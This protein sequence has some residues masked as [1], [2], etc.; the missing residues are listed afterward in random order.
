MT[1]AHWV[2]AQTPARTM[3][4]TMRIWPINNLVGVTDLLPPAGLDRFER[5]QESAKAF[6]KD[7]VQ[8]GPD[9]LNSDAIYGFTRSSS[10]RSGPRSYRKL[11]D[12][13]ACRCFDSI[14]QHTDGPGNRLEILDAN[15]VRSRVT[16]L[17]ISA[18]EKFEQAT[19]CSC[20]PWPGGDETRFNVFG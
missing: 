16:R 9:R 2:A 10:D 14:P 18:F 5:V 19:I 17:D 12:S 11:F 6:Q 15:V 8:I 13:L 7:M 3:A 4:S 20:A 1:A